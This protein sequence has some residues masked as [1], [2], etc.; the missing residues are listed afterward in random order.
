VLRRVRPALRSALCFPRRLAGLVRLRGDRLGGLLHGA[1]LLAGLGLGLL[2]ALPLQDVSGRCPPRG[3]GYD[4][5]VLQ[6]AWLPMLLLVLAGAFLGQFAAR[7]MLVRMPAW[8]ER[9][10]TVGERRVGEEEAREEPPYSSDP[11]LLAATWGEK[12]GPSERRRPSILQ[13]LRRR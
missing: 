2:L 12:K 5:C 3:E 1:F 9:L 10:R 8:R 11:F 7:V 4:L 13:R 6:R